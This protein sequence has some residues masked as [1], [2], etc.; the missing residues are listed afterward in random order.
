MKSIKNMIKDESGVS[1]IVATLV[2]IVVAVVGAVA[3][4]TIMGTFSSDVADQN[5]AGD[6]GSASATEI[7]VVGSTTVQPASVELAKEYMKLHPGIKITVQGGGSGAGVTAAGE[8]IADIGSSSSAIDADDYEN[9]PLLE[10]YQIGGSAVV[11]ITNDDGALIINGTTKEGLAALYAPALD[12]DEDGIVAWTDD[13]DKVI[14][15]TDTFTDDDGAGA[16]DITLYQRD[17]ASGT[18]DTTSEFIDGTKSFFNDGYSVGVT[19]NGGVLE[20]VAGA[21]GPAIGFV[22]FGFAASNDDVT[23]LKVDGMA[24]TSSNIKAALKGTESYPIDLT[25]GLYYVT[26]GAPGSIVSNYIQFVQ[27]PAGLDIMESEDVGMFGYLSIA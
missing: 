21:T 8:G 12:A 20:S 23:M 16:N 6:V 17:E 1:P 3:V 10:V 26:N 22:D 14:E 27:S 11:W 24:A 15:G 2:L 9:Y 18:E 25:R 13:G 7:L 5:N 4:G 19:G